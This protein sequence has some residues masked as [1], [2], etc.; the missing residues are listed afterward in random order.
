LP[1]VPVRP[2]DNFGNYVPPAAIEQLKSNNFLFP[3]TADI[4]F[5]FDVQGQNLS[6]NWKTPVGS[7]G[8]GTAIA[9]KTRAGQRSELQPLGIRTWDAF[10][11]QVNKLDPKRYIF[12]GQESNEWRLRTSFYRTGRA[13]LERYLSRDIN[14]LQKSLSSL[15][16]HVFDLTNNL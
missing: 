11:K 9:P 7:F 8:G 2:I 15:T 3:E 1:N 13:D 6:V 12:R 5:D 14:D 16:N 4:D 10:K